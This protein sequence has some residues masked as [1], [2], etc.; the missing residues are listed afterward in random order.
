L[1][2]DAVGSVEPCSLQEFHQPRWCR[3]PRVE[4]VVAYDIY[5]DS[6]DVNIRQ[7]NSLLRGLLKVLLKLRAEAVV[8]VMAKRVA[9]K[10]PVA[11][12]GIAEGMHV[13]GTSSP[14]EFFRKTKQFHTADVST[15]IKQDV[16]LLAG[17]EDHL[18][19]M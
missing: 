14:Y 16:L 15:L 19:P 9:K 1:Q 17:S 10:S 8:N 12:W 18:V 6:L 7:V 4:R 2:L 11:E 3:P 5:P 13:T